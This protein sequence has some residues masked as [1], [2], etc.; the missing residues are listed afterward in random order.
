MEVALHATPS[1]KPIAVLLLLVLL[2]LELLPLATPV[3][4]T[5]AEVVVVLA[6]LTV[7]PSGPEGIRGPLVRS[8]VVSKRVPLT[9]A[10]TPQGIAE[11]SG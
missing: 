8:S 4:Q 10:P 2:V 7:R 3:P 5:H 1:M 11:P 9:R 6:E